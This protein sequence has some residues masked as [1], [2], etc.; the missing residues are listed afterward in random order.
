MGDYIGDGGMIVKVGNQSEDIFERDKESA[1][2][3]GS[4]PGGD[5]RIVATVQVRERFKKKGKN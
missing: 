3:A 1:W 5:V 2:R 4:K